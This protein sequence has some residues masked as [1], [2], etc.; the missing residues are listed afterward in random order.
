MT[1]SAPPQ[2]TVP[3]VEVLILG[4]GFSGQCAAIELKRAG[5][6]DFV[7]LEKAHEV[8]GTWRDNDYPGAACDVPS[9]LY[10]FSFAPKPDWSHTFARQPEILAYLKDTARNHGLLP[11]IHFGTE[12]VQC[13]FDETSA[14]WHVATRNGAV[15]VARVLVAA[16]GPLSRPALPELPG[17]ATFQGAAFH[18]AAWNHDL[19]LRGKRVAVIGSGASAIQFVPRIAPLTGRLDFYQRTPPWVLPR[20]DGVRK[21]WQ[22]ALFRH[23][24]LLQKLVRG[25]VYAWLESRVVGFTKHP[26]AMRVVE[27]L[28]R[29]HLRRQIADP[30]LREALTP[31]Y[32]AGCKRILMANDYYPALTLPHVQVVTTPIR[33]VTPRGI[34]TQD[35]QVREVDALIF[36]TGFQ[37]H[38]PVDRGAV[39]GLQGLDLA[40]VW[41]D[42]PQAYLGTAVAGFPNL[43][44]VVGPN[45]G[46][47]H[48]SMV[49]VIESQVRYLVDAIRTL[50]EQRL[51][52][53]E[54]R[55]EVQAAYNDDLQRRL[56]GTVWNTGGCRSW[57]LAPNGRNTS[58]WP[59]FTFLM[60]RRM[61]R[62]DVGSYRVGP[63]PAA[64]ST[65]APDR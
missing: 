26:R 14:T 1:V 2:P 51:G 12:A 48:S 38:A 41:R 13:R 63:V 15:Y 54:V 18:S 29:R 25:L 16:M 58:L 59:T 45:T 35:G 56:A 23:V 46:L 33:E 60:R 65:P 47:G 36:A 39:L 24:P 9:H 50:R 3:F 8:G 7:M 61:R 6:H 57:Y 44:F 22:H 42:G 10:S 30:A 53:L 17:L 37:V 49:Y 11:H 31:S 62:F 5:I 40:E 19:D 64:A 27:W 32:T 52:T 20:A 55:P 28:C 4:T 34:V 21:P 43:F